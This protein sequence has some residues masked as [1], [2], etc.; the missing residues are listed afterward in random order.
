M[1]RVDHGASDLKPLCC[2]RSVISFPV[3]LEVL[4]QSVE[5]YR[6]LST[7]NLKVELGENL[8]EMSENSET[9]QPR[10]LELIRK[11]IFDNQQSISRRMEE[12]IIDQQEQSKKF[13][14][15]LQHI[16]PRELSIAAPNRVN[17]IPTSANQSGSTSVA[18]EIEF[19]M[20]F[21]KVAGNAS[22]LSM[23]PVKRFTRVLP[24]ITSQSLGSTRRT[25]GICFAWLAR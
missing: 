3:N 12:A 25:S 8:A 17:Y 11:H 7:S 10:Y 5:A 14:F 22:L 23:I 18:Q 15:R 2:F 6:S 16:V 13:L 20:T 4:R 9:S 24:F 19:Q 1:C 21:G